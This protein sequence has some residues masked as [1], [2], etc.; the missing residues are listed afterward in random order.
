MAHSTSRIR[1]SAVESGGSRN[2]QWCPGPQLTPLASLPAQLPAHHY[3]P[4]QAHI[5]ELHQV[6]SSAIKARPNP[7]R[8]PTTISCATQTISPG[9]SI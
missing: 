1:W 5:L 2:N 3:H 8:R 7:V 6:Q 9:G 4:H